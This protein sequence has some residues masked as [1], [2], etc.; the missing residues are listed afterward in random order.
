[1][2]EILVVTSK[3]GLKA[4]LRARGSRRARAPRSMIKHPLSIEKS[5]GRALSGEVAIALNMV[6]MRIIPSLSDFLRKDA[7]RAD[8]PAALGRA[9]DEVQIVFGARASGSVQSAARNAAAQTSS[10]NRRQTQRAVRSAIGIQPEMSEPWLREESEAFVR[11]NVRLITKV[12]DV[13]FDRVE[14]TID[15]GIRGGK[16]VEE[17]ARE[18]EASLPEIGAEA[19]R[20]AMLIARDQV[21][22]FFGDLTRRRQEDL[23]VRKYTWR[24]SNDER[25][26]PTHRERDGHVFL[27]SEPIE[28]QLEELGL[29][30][31][32]ID[33]SPGIPMQCRCTAEPDFSDLLT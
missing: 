5:F 4:A 19:E 20:R 23:G 26:R 29:E 18:I 31:D 14:R 21:G 12:S 13:V 27:W 6:R 15:Q 3:E 8:A 10:E 11:R 30:V 9:I 1:M 7:A 32:D 24:D 22:S 2:P 16:R 33:G 28:P 25:V 17:L